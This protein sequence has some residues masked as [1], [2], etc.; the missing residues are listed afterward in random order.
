MPASQ[1][2]SYSVLTM[3]RRP[4]PPTQKIQLESKAGVAG[5]AAWTTGVRSEPQ[6]ITTVVDVSTWSAAVALCGTYQALIGTVVALV[7]A[8]V[9]LSYSALIL[10]VDAQPEPIR[11]G[12][13]GLSGTSGALVRAR[14][15]IETRA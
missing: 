13:G 9:S 14:W 5:N 1:I 6:Q 7:Y 15:T 10:D 11:L 4:T 8:G 3:D 2:G 12:A